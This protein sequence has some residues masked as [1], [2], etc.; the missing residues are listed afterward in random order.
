MSLSPVALGPPIGVAGMA[1]ALSALLSDEG[2]MKRM[3]APPG[4]PA[5]AA[6][7]DS[8]VAFFAAAQTDAGRLVLGPLVGLILV[9]TALFGLEARIRVLPQCCTQLCIVLT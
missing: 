2:V 8:M 5:A 3:Q 4:A 6:F 1:A 9:A 7:L